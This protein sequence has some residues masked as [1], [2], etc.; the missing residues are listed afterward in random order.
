M[1]ARLPAEKL[2]KAKDLV[3]TTLNK[4]T[5]TR[6]KL[7]TL[8]GICGL[9]SQNGGAG[10]NFSPTPFQLQNRARAPIYE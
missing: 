6:N 9:C 8:A 2:Q 7:D 5:I 10:K 4:S 1:Q 3:Q